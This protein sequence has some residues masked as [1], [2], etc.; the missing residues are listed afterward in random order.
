MVYIVCVWGWN[1]C[2]YSV[3][4][5]NVLCNAGLGFFVEWG[6]GGEGGEG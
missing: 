4:W 5:V 1:A 3:N 2:V 6:G